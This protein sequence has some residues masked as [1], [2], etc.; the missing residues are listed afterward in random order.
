[1][2]VGKESIR[3]AASAGAKR[4]TKTTAKTAAKATSEKKTVKKSVVSPQDTKK[5][6]AVFVTE[7]KNETV[8]GPVR[9]KEE[10]P[11]IILH[12]DKLLFPSLYPKQPTLL[13]FGVW[14]VFL[15]FILYFI[16]EDIRN[17][18]RCLIRLNF[19]LLQIGF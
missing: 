10:L 8:E 5:L 13:F 4:T 15:I 17:P 12:Q 11:A 14:A 18:L 6:E 9:I 7:N 3:R 19:C 1:M 16:Q 2:S